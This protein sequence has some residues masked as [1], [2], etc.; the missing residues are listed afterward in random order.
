MLIIFISAINQTLSL[1][2]TPVYSTEPS[3]Q[4]T[5]PFLFVDIDHHWAMDAILRAFEK[6][7]D[8]YTLIEKLTSV[9]HSIQHLQQKTP[10][11]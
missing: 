5:K 3:D 9:F 8:L 10:L 11:C 6:N 2:L 4:I 1:L 7:I